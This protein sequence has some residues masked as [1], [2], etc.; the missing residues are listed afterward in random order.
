VQVGCCASARGVCWATYGC[1]SLHSV[2]CSNPCTTSLCHC[3]GWWVALL[4]ASGTR[5]TGDCLCVPVACD[6]RHVLASICA[7][8][9]P[10]V[11]FSNDMVETSQHHPSGNNL[12]HLF[13]RAQAL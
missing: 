6:T 3:Q 12:L 8:A 4:H 9:L 11:T 5:I 2:S 7:S 1:A 10:T 13:C